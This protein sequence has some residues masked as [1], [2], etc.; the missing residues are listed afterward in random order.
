M[1]LECIK[2]KVQEEYEDWTRE[3]MVSWKLWRIEHPVKN[4]KGEK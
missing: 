3:R 2:K 1:T 4:E